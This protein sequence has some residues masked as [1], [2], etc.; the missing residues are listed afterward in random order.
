MGKVAQLC[1]YASVE[2]TDAG[3]AFLCT[4]VGDIAGLKAP[5]VELVAALVS[6][7]HTLPKSFVDWLLCE[8]GKRADLEHITPAA[9]AAMQI[10][11]A[12]HFLHLGCELHVAEREYTLLRLLELED[13]FSEAVSFLRQLSGKLEQFLVPP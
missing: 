11:L 8:L 9:H 4:L 1:N 12:S 6:V 5:T 10:G 7:Q 3:R 2:K 13:N